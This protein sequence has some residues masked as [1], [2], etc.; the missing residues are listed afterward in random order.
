M[1][2]NLVTESDI[3][4]LLPELGSYLWQGENNF[5][6]QREA[7]E[8]IVKNDLARD[9]DIND[10]MP[11]LWLRRRGA[12]ITS[13][14]ITEITE[15]VPEGTAPLPAAGVPKLKLV[16][17]TFTYSGSSLKSFELEGKENGAWVSAD[18][19]KINAAGIIC[20]TL[21][22]S[23]DE[24]RISLDVPDGAIDYEAYLTENSYD[25]LFAYKWLEIILNDLIKEKG[26]QFG[27]KRDYFARA[28][29]E[30]RSSAAFLYRGGV[31][32]GNIL[33]VRR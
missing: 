32:R 30:L 12:A 25:L 24:Y 2:R 19:F 23:Y 29:D 18:S 13:I 9:F 11:E 14:D 3:K 20:R 26:D 33:K 10:L 22:K 4:K 6:G 21:S 27:L 17:K 1:L 7:A 28:Y 15:P 8:M 31:S 16:C 5:S